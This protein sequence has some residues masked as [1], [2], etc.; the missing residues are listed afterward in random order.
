MFKRL[1]LA[2]LASVCASASSHATV[3]TGDLAVYN[4]P[5]LVGYISDAFD[6]QNSF[7]KT[8][9]VSNALSVSINSTMALFS[10]DAVNPPEL[11]TSLSWSGR[12]QWWLL[13]FIHQPR[14]RLSSRHWSGCGWTTLFLGGHEHPVTRLRWTGRSNNLVT[15]GQYHH[16][17][18][19]EY[20][21]YGCSSHAFL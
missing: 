9:S 16:G 21:R 14:L 17:A 8:A 1:V 18:M 20:R 13:L 12:R 7:T 15:H 11:L 4:G 6:G 2:A 5:T 3:V 10:I 19:G